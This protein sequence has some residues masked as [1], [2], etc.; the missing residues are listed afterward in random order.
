MLSIELA[1]L[2]ATVLGFLFDSSG[3]GVWEGCAFLGLTRARQLGDGPPLLAAEQVVVLVDGHFDAGVAHELAHGRDVAT[4]AKERR[5]EQV[6]DVE[7][8]HRIGQAG[9]FRRRLQRP[10]KFPHRPAIVLDNVAG[11]G[12]RLHGLE[13][14]EKLRRGWMVRVI[15]A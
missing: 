10:A 14:I 12:L 2:F 6:P 8:D 1:A 3:L 9:L 5:G 15:F 11:L 7:H 4:F 13:T